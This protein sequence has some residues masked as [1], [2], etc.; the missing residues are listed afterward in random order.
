MVPSSWQIST[1]TGSCDSSPVSRQPGQLEGRLVAGTPKV[2]DIVTVRIAAI[3]QRNGVSFESVMSDMDA[4][5]EHTGA[6]GLRG[7]HRSVEQALIARVSPLQ[8]S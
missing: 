5:H 2:W 6:F 3:I 4:L 7:S 1:T 8:T